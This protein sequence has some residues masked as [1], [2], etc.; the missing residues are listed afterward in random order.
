[1]FHNLDSQSF[2]VGAAYS[3]WF[4][5]KYILLTFLCIMLSFFILRSSVLK[6]TPQSQISRSKCRDRSVFDG[7]LNIFKAVNTYHFPIR[8]YQFTPSHCLGSMFV[9]L[10]QLILSSPQEK[11]IPLFT[12]CSLK[13]LVPARQIILRRSDVPVMMK[14]DGCRWNCT[15]LLQLEGGYK[16]IPQLPN[17]YTSSPTDKSIEKNNLIVRYEIQHNIL[18]SFKGFFFF[19]IERRSWCGAAG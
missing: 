16:S 15:K 10:R 12:W 7:D 6:L 5:V 3:K 14:S 19:L 17:P 18:R 13:V 9:Y 8:L 1:M 4:I 2:I 11:E